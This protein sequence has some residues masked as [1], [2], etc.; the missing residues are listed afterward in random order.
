MKK[1]IIAIIVAALSVSVYAAGEKPADKAAGTAQVCPVKETCS[2]CKAAGTAC[3]AC[4]AKAD[5][6]KAVQD[7]TECS[8]GVCPLKK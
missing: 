2:A 5:A 6:A 7:K 8:G 4:K 3:A 1:F